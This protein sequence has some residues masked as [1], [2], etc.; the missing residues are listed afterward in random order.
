MNVR[1]HIK[2]TV[3]VIT[4]LSA[5][6]TA[7][8]SAQD[9]VQKE[10]RGLVGGSVGLGSQ[11]RLYDDSWA[12]GVQGALELR[13]SFHLVGTVGWVLSSDWRIEARENVFCY[14]SPSPDNTQSTRNDV[15]MSFGVAYHVR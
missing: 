11:R 13:P 5:A 4:G 14:R 8:L 10:L 2:R 6:L 9:A 1:S 7:T 12:V 3:G 15:T